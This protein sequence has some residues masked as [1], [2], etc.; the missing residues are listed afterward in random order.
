MELDRT[1]KI[2][3]E[4]TENN[5]VESE[6]GVRSKRRKALPRALD[7]LDIAIIPVTIGV[8]VSLGFLFAGLFRAAAPLAA[9][10]V[11]SVLAAVL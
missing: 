7:A 9:T 10:T 11:G 8:F 4:V 2:Q 3:V 6:V 1:K 5:I